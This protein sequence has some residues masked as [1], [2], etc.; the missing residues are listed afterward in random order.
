M[1]MVGLIY[2]FNKN[3]YSTFAPTKV[4]GKVAGT[5]LGGGKG[6]TDWNYKLN[7]LPF[8]SSKGKN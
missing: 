2:V 6:M 1:I 4:I 5:V 7:T 3:L 8:V